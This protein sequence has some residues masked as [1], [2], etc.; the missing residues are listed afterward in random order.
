MNTLIDPC[1]KGNTELSVDC[2]HHITFPLHRL[3]PFF[4]YV[5]SCF[6]T[7]DLLV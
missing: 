7:F 1:N 3:F 5:L 2:T 4:V 6:S